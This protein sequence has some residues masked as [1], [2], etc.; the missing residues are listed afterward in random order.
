MSNITNLQFF[1]LENHYSGFIGFLIIGFTVSRGSYL[2]I[3]INITQI[4][5]FIFDYSQYY[6]YLVHYLSILLL[7]PEERRINC[8][9]K[10]SRL[11]QRWIMFNNA[12]IVT[13]SHGLVSLIFHCN[14]PV[15]NSLLGIC[16][17][18]RTRND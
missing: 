14:K 4:L 13:Y 12:K 8:V 7:T 18:Q 1:P 9:N 17:K 11:L 2:F 6:L 5:M 15:L 3:A 10:F 16:E